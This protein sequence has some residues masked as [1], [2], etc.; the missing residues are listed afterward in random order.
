MIKADHDW[1][2]PTTPE[3][4]LECLSDPMWR[5]CSGQM[6]RIMIK[7]GDDD[8]GSVIPF[9]P[10]RSQRRLLSRLWY[11]NIILKARQLGFT[12]L[13]AIL[14]LDHALFNADQRCGIIA[15]DR[16]SAEAIFRDKV[17]LAYDRMPEEI[18]ALMP[19]ARD[20]AA[21]LLFSNNSSIRVATS[22]RSGTIHRLHISEFGK[23]CAKFPEKAAEVVTGSLPAVPDDGIAII[24][25]T[26]EGR[27]GDYYKM[28]QRAIGQADAK[29]Q[30]TAKDYRFHFYAWWQDPAYRMAATGVVIT[31]KDREYFGIIESQTG[32]KLDDEQRNWYVATRDATFS[33]S[34]QK[35]WQEYPSTPTEAFQVSTEGN[36]YVKQIAA[37]RKQGRIVRVPVLEVPVNTFWDIGNGD[38]C[39]I[40]CHQQV[41]PEDRFINYHEAHG[42]SLLY[43]VKWLRDTGYLFN[44]HFLPHDAAHKR[45][46]DTNNSTEEMLN[47]LGLIN[48][49]IVPII[50]D[51]NTGIQ[52]T[53]K[54]FASAIFDEEG[55]KQGFSR[56]ENYKKKWNRADSRWG[57]EPDKANGCSEGADAF[58]QYAQAK[59]GQLI[60]LA[61]R[62]AQSRSRPPPD[63][64]T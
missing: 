12:T 32:T 27:D 9:R 21:E 30:L 31:D 48:T 40:W 24:E 16:D 55:T 54:H 49:V 33:G 25:S 44:K 3:E 51:L 10:N 20:S 4:L 6:Y 22:M 41:G 7:K 8:Q 61:G 63:W 17:K 34:D 19:L 5:V 64:R 52:M 46:S 47:E 18:K 13:V 14:W 37:V 36:Y 23:I 39:G 1:M 60:T 58:R 59:E 42:E 29:T 35:M 62:T 26:A 43:Y 56:L 57:D 28:V 11:R 2:V 50:T 38:G 45:L 53:R 15:Q